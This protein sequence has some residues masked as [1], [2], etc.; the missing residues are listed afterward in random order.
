MESVEG[1][2]E[3]AP[4]NVF[5]EGVTINQVDEETFSVF[6]PTPGAMNEAQ[7]FIG[8]IC[9]DDVRGFFWFFFVAL[10]V[11]KVCL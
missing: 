1:G 11:S 2:T 10:C 9:K 3:G 5:F 4:R 7:E 8:E 6:A